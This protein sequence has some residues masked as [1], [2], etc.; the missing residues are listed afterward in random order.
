MHNLPLELVHSIF[1]EEDG[2]NGYVLFKC[3]V[4]V[5]HT[6]CED[7]RLPLL[8]MVGRLGTTFE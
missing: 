5:I 3:I 7:S 2:D 1:L 6:I 4:G 8:R